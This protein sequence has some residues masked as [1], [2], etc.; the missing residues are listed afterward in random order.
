MVSNFLF[1]YWYRVFMEV[2]GQKTLIANYSS[3][4]RPPDAGNV[5]NIRSFRDKPEYPDQVKIVSV[6]AHAEEDAPETGTVFHL[7][8]EPA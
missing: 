6:E 7:M 4:T 8:V 1:I 5:I 2:D 3:T